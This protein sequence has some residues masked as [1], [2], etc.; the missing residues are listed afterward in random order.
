MKSLVNLFSRPRE[1][2]PVV[3]NL[4]EENK[5]Y[6]NRELQRWVEPGMEESV[7]K[8]MEVL[9]APPPK[10]PAR[11]TPSSTPLPEPVSAADQLC[12]VANYHY[13]GPGAHDRPLSRPKVAS[14]IPPLLPYHPVNSDS[15]LACESTD[16]TIEHLQ[17]KTL[18]PD[19]K[20][21][22]PDPH[23]PQNDTLLEPGSFSHLNSPEPAV[24]SNGYGGAFDLNRPSTIP[25]EH[26]SSNVSP[27]QLARPS[28]FGI[29]SH[30]MQPTH[31][32]YPAI[33]QDTRACPTN[34]NTNEC[35]TTHQDGVEEPS[36]NY[37]AT[38]Y[39]SQPPSVTQLQETAMQHVTEHGTQ[40]NLP[41]DRVASREHITDQLPDQCSAL[42]STT[43][44]LPDTKPL[45]PYLDNATPDTPTTIDAK[46]P[47]ILNSTSLGQLNEASNYHNLLHVTSHLEP[48]GVPFNSISAL[49]TTQKDDTLHAASLPLE[50][51]V[52]GSTASSGSSLDQPSLYDTQAYPRNPYDL[53]RVMSPWNTTIASMSTRTEPIS[54]TSQAATAGT[55]CRAAPTLLDDMSPTVIS[56]TGPAELC[57]T[58]STACP[59]YHRHDIQYPAT[60]MPP[61][62]D[63]PQVTAAAS[64]L[65][66][67]R[68]RHT[69]DDVPPSTKELPHAPQDWPASVSKHSF[70]RRHDQLYGGDHHQQ[71]AAACPD[72]TSQDISRN[73]PLSAIHA[74]VSRERVLE[75][76]PFLSS[77]TV[78]DSTTHN[79]PCSAL[80]LSSSFSP[81]GKK[82]HDDAAD[83]SLPPAAL[84]CVAAAV[85]KL[86]CLVTHVHTL[87]LSSPSKVLATEGISSRSDDY[88][89]FSTFDVSPTTQQD[90]DKLQKDLDLLNA[91]VADMTSQ[92]SAHIAT[93]ATG[94]ARLEAELT[95]KR[96]ADDGRS[97]SNSDAVTMNT[98]HSTI[99][100]L[101]HTVT[102]ATNLVPQNL[103]DHLNGILLRLQDTLQTVTA[104]TA[105]LERQYAAQLSQ[106]I[107]E[108]DASLKDIRIAR[109]ELEE[110][111]ASI[112]EHEGSWKATTESC[113]RSVETQCEQRLLALERLLVQQR[114]DAEERLVNE[115]RSTQDLLKG[116]EELRTREREQ[117]AQLRGRL[118]SAH[119]ELKDVKYQ[120]LFALQQKDEAISQLTLIKQDLETQ[121]ADLQTEND[122]RLTTLK[123]QYAALETEFQQTRLD[124]AKS[125]DHSAQQT[126]ELRRLKEENEEHIAHITAEYQ[127]DV[128]DLQQAVASLTTEKHALEIRFAE[129]EKQLALFTTEKR[130]AEEQIADAQLVRS[131]MESALAQAE[132]EKIELRA[133]ID[134]LNNQCAGLTTERMKL[135]SEIQI[136]SQN[137]GEE[138][139]AF[140]QDKEKAVAALKT[141]IDGLEQQLSQLIVDK[142]MAKREL[143]DYTEEMSHQMVAMQKAHESTEALLRDTVTR[144]EAELE[145][146]KMDSTDFKSKM[147]TQESSL[148]SKVAALE[149]QVVELTQE[150]ETLLQHSRDI[151]SDA[152][153]QQSR[154]QEVCDN[155]SD[156][157]A[158]LRK[159]L[160]ENPPSILP[161]S[162]SQT[163]Q[164]TQTDAPDVV[165]T[166]TSTTTKSDNNEATDGMTETTRAPLG[167]LQAWDD[168]RSDD[169]VLRQQQY[170]TELFE[171]QQKLTDTMNQLRKTNT[172]LEVA[173]QKQEDATFMLK[174]MAV[175]WDLV[176]RYHPEVCREIDAR[177]P[178]LDTMKS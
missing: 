37:M 128:S 174:H 175:K 106:S 113:I 118:T 40:E 63:P 36:K 23:T 7:R 86:T 64:A 65:P 78:P 5:M 142:D 152:D 1:G 21:H 108:R 15:S 34:T 81:T 85:D 95:D 41:I 172:D 124:L 32:G 35:P 68:T 71:H 12:Q 51:H 45:K 156:Q 69:A 143:A 66:S 164:T 105:N 171:T 176:L 160:E 84:D 163:E 70:E 74:P 6:Y 61:V 3:A 39:L 141:Q 38:P 17:S 117:E 53:Q 46:R 126:Q 123:V 59:Q 166:S 134:N 83:S 11:T 112:T 120:H 135:L 73:V 170:E 33:S 107:A 96:I 2:G 47:V 80:T 9:S 55:D 48:S 10:S 104:V 67:D 144:L 146:A 130:S 90:E 19:L 99:A 44:T 14:L 77:A 97:R 178:S 167:A 82:P 119:L 161:P 98:L 116:F 89:G 88:T 30:T 60:D 169:W 54:L 125:I 18:P 115:Q 93:L 154:L 52:Q 27:P 137:M 22:H 49:Q 91:R 147:E 24:T 31:S 94:V 162:V 25:P 159:Q 62:T 57:S 114:F 20:T 140:I 75:D 100:T 111:S 136:Q 151:K 177:V 157:I 103:E 133:V 173:I 168:E 56:G 131:Q 101:L 58:E 127:T 72:T 110:L 150:N 8:E 149:A 4:G 42:P 29:S 153:Q 148:Q 165:H 155:Q 158:L 43:S 121:L 76:P 139:Q 16:D 92:C 109:R 122:A 50:V 132:T 102:Q 79:E 26:N 138:A 129:L 87:A 28:S 145:N 13:I